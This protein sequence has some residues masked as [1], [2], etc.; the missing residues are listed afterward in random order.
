MDQIRV[1]TQD[2]NVGRR[3]VPMKHLLITA[4]TIGTA[5]T[6]YT[7]RDGVLFLVKHAS[8][9]N[10]GASPVDLNL[11]A[12]PSGG[13]IGDSNAEVIGYSIAANDAVDLTLLMGQLYEQGDTLQAFA[14]SASALVLHGWG[15]EIL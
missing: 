4:T 12:V 15:E 7:V 5:Q 8:V 3:P 11:Y 9:E 14:S 13:T 6:W 2:S 1:R 10:V